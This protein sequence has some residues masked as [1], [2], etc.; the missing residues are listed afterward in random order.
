MAK[1]IKIFP[2]WVWFVGVCVAWAIVLPIAWRNVSPH[3]FH[4]LLIF[5]A[6]FMFGAVAASIARK[7]YK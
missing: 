6:G 2:Y 4:D 7:V 1:L 3:R 5:F